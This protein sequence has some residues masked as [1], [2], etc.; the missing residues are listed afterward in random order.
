MSGSSVSPPDRRRKRARRAGL[1][2]VND[3]DE[4]I[5]RRRCG[6]GFTY[7][8][9]SG[10]TLKSRYIRRRIESLAIPPAWNDV[11]ICPKPD[12]HV[13]ARGVD[14]AGRIQAIYHPQWRAVSSEKKFDRMLDFAAVLPKIRRT[15]RSDLARSRMD[16]RKVTAAV[17]RILDRGHLRVGNV[18]YAENGD[19]RGATTLAAEHVEVQKF[20]ISLQFP[21]K[22]GQQREVE[23]RDAK[24]AKV[25]QQCE[26]LDGR[27]LFCYIG[28]DGNSHPVSS[29]D[30]ND[31][32]QDVTD[33]HVTAKD[34]R[35]WWGSVYA[36]ES[37]GKIDQPEGEAA[38]KRA[39][40]SAVKEVARKL[41]NTAAVCRQSYIHPKILEAASNG[42]L[43]ALI[44]TAQGSVLH[45][46]QHNEMRKSESLLT[47][48][49]HSMH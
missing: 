27:F 31:W 5:S 8:L 29:T 7:R 4:G 26:D 25:I 1:Y 45:E 47:A 46:H 42:S 49:L 3:F 41:G 24:T 2:Y 37:L 32:L 15:V 18:R 12:G 33:E 30:V 21:G 9:P 20:R 19:S 34:F 11:W 39:L 13:L 10:K 14:A 17:I 16:K 23:F 48:L 6:R 22:S 28:S 38:S 43:H 35:T 40:T 44:S 36:L